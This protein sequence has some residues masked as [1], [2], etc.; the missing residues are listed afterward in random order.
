MLFYLMHTL[1]EYLLIYIFMQPEVDFGLKL[2][3]GDMM[4]IPGLYQFIQVIFVPLSVYG[5]G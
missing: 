4:A 1:N 2:V 5:F 3:G